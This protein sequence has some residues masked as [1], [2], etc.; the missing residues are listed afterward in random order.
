MRFVFRS[1]ASF[2]IGAGH[3]MR[4][5][6]IAEEA[7]SQGIQCIF[8]GDIAG[9]PWIEDK[10]RNLG[11]HQVIGNESEFNP[12][13][14]RDV[15]ILDSYSIPTN[16]K[17]IDPRDWLTVVNIFDSFTPKY[18]SN[19]RIHPGIEKITEAF[20]Y[21]KTLSGPEYVPIR[22]S[23][24]KSLPTLE[25]RE[26]RI[27]VVGGGTDVKGFVTAIAKS[28]MKLD[29]NFK[30]CLVTATPTDLSLDDRFELIQPG[31]NI[32]S[33]FLDTDVALTTASTTALEF[34]ALGCAVGI[35]CAVENQKQNYYSLT[36]LGIVAPIGIHVNGIWELEHYE[37]NTLLSEI[38]FRNEI[39]EKA[40]N[41]ID[42]DGA[43]RIVDA[44]LEI[45]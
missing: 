17:F 9:I 41:F 40:R 10:V 18:K 16:H 13:S 26:L 35:A 21:G 32:D 5:S 14:Q 43:K 19:L 31:K 44:I 8:V 2:S 23:I 1:D 24:R 15:L 33:I 36:E 29:I 42:K 37:L 30:A 34:L 39:K 20:T 7:I 45:I 4:S 38:S 22:K 28:L 27:T 25:G 12:S 11:F 3:V 6:A